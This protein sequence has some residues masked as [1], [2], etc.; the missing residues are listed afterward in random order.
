MPKMSSEQAA[1]WIDLANMTA[2]LELM[3]RGRRTK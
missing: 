1:L 2:W 3:P